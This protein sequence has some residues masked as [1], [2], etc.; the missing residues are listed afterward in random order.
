MKPTL[1]P[2]WIVINVCVLTLTACGQ[3]AG[4]ADPLATTSTA[5][6][7]A[8]STN[9]PAPTATE[10]PPT[11]TLAPSP[12]PTLAIPAVLEAG[13]TVVDGDGT[14]LIYIPAGEFLMG[15]KGDDTEYFV[16]NDYELPRHKVTLD[17]YWI[18]QTEVSI[19]QYKACVSAGKCVPPAITASNFSESYYDDPKYENHP[20]IELQWEGAF[21]YCAWVNRRLPTEAEWEKAAR[22]D[23]GRMYPWG[24]EEPFLLEDNSLNYHSEIGSTTPVTE[25]FSDVSPYGVYNMAGNVSEWVAD[26]FHPHYYEVSP[27]IN[28]LGPE[29]PPGSV[30]GFPETHVRRGG[31]YYSDSFGVRTVFRGIDRHDIGF[32]CARSE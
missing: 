9:T 27:S 15:A 10:P 32:R 25:H 11:V 20:V 16:P 22:G 18:D 19:K 7:V 14:T 5:E 21:N 3:N 8:S 24:D 29:T 30:D 23:D 2:I 28:P 17:A 26:W 1:R 12:T 4:P 13:T 31:S 6:P